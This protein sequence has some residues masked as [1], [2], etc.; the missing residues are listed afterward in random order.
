MHLIQNAVAVACCVSLGSCRLDEASPWLALPLDLANL[1]VHE[2]FQGD[3]AEPAVQ[4]ALHEMA[5]VNSQKVSAMRT[6]WL[7]SPAP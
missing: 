5:L 1:L 7:L 6:D 2:S 3:A 4:A